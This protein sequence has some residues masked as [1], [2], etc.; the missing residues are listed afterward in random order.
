MF[1]FELFEFQ[2]TVFI[3]KIASNWYQTF[4]RWYCDLSSPLP[5]IVFLNHF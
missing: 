3:T 4:L 1:E 2:I 5:K